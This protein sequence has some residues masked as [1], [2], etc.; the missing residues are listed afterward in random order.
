M[1]SVTCSFD[2]GE[3][4]NC[5]LPL[6][7]D[8]GRFGTDN[9]TVV[10]TATD[11]FGQT[12]SISLGFRLTAPGELKNLLSIVIMHVI[13]M[14]S[15]PADLRVVC[16]TDAVPGRQRFFCDASNPIASIMCSFD[17]GVAEIC[18]FP[19]VAELDRFGTDSHTLVVTLVDV[20]GQSTSVSLDFTLIERKTFSSSHQ[21]LNFHL[22]C[23]GSTSYSITFSNTTTR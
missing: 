4:E 8:I 13:S 20:F 3:A 14:Y 6:I 2:G 23:S 11:E 19:V 15:P 22:I 9:H 1:V 12:S 5:T 17:G 10:L 7:V 16:G 18:S 21:K